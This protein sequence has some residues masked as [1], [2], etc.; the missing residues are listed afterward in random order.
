MTNRIK[1]LEGKSEDFANHPDNEYKNTKI[2]SNI[3][4]KQLEILD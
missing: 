1:D 3:M 2:K 4:D